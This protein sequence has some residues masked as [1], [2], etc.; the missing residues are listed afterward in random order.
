MQQ[1]VEFQPLGIEGC[2]DVGA[3][4]RQGL[5]LPVRLTAGCGDGATLESQGEAWGKNWLPL[6]GSLCSAAGA[7]QGPGTL[8]GQGPVWGRGAHSVS[9]L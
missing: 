3:L 8:V 2:R 6:Q 1:K 5:G 9:H 4:H 7:D